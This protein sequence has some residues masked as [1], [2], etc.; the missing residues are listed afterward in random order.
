MLLDTSLSTI[1]PVDLFCKLTKGHFL[2]LHLIDLSVFLQL[3]PR[4]IRINTE[5]RRLCRGNSLVPV[6]FIG[7]MVYVIVNGLEWYI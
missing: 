4:E 7:L 5:N 1:R 6:Y 2:V 3:I